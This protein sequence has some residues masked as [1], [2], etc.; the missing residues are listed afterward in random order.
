MLPVI[1]LMCFADGIVDKRSAESGWSELCRGGSGLK[2][3]V[4]LKVI[5]K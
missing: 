4:K 5:F 1:I 2:S 3:E